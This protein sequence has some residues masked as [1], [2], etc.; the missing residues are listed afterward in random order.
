LKFAIGIHNHQ[1]VGNFDSV[2]EE[3]YQLSYWPFLNAFAR[4]D[5]LKLNLH[6]SGP[7]WDFVRAKH[8]EYVTLVKKLVAEGRLELLTGGYYEPILPIIP[9]EDR[10]GQIRKLSR[11]LEH[12]LGAKPRGMWLAERVWEPHLPRSL[13]AAGVGFCITDDEHFRAAGVRES[14]MNGWFLTED[15]GAT[16]GVVPINRPLRHAIPFS[17]VPATLHLLDELAERDPD[18]LVLFADDG[19]KFGVWPETKVL[20]YDKKWLEHF[21]EG[22]IKRARRVETVLLSD[23]IDARRPA[24][25]VYLPS[26]SYSEMMSWA[27]PPEQ[28]KTLDRL[29]GKLRFEGLLERY[30]GLVQGAHWRSFLAKYPEANRLHKRVLG[31]SRAVHAAGAVSSSLGD[32]PLDALWQAQCNCAYWHGAFGGLYFPHL[33][34][35]LW[36]K[37]LE[38]EAAV[39]RREPFSCIV[40]DVDC[41]GHAD[42]V[43]RTPHLNAFWSTQDAALYELDHLPTRTNLCDTLARRPEAYH[44]EGGTYDA[45]PRDCFLDRFYPR[46]AHLSP[47]AEDCGTF[48]P[49]SVQVDGATF[50]LTREGSVKTAAGAV[51]VKIVK[52][53]TTSSSGPQIEVAYKVTPAVRLEMRFAV[54]LNF[55]MQAGH[56]PDER[57]VEVNGSKPTDRRLGATA[58]HQAVERVR[59][60]DT[61]RKVAVTVVPSRAAVLWRYPV[62][63][64]SRMI[65]GAERLFQAVGL[66]LGWDLDLPAGQPFAVQLV[67]QLE[68]LA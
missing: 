66:E 52:R 54:E 6:N 23:A 36:S 51:P 32:G 10:V 3:A 41:D 67:L 30:E 65:T 43:V 49:A 14:E 13:Q 17:S 40:E 1:P 46:G 37:L 42:V 18:G 53:V 19:E 27:L 63:T 2:V 34:G 29:R 26:A 16:V 56:T 21:F 48:A 7:V 55:G 44:A 15:L 25:R 57:F 5:G 68:A 47:R 31:V 50:T 45:Q 39:P 11:F 33:R 28:G 61:W 35:A 58:E 38:A 9:E 62:E 8:P 59:V 60:A 12:E 64:Q 20:V 22:L 24:G 4:A